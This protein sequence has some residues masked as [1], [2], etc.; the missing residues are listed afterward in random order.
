LLLEGD[1]ELLAGDQLLRDQHVPQTYSRRGGGRLH[2]GLYL[3]VVIWDDVAS[4]LT[5]SSP[6]LPHGQGLRLRS[7][8]RC[9]TNHVSA[10]FTELLGIHRRRRSEQ[11]R[12]RRRRRGDGD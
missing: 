4:I 5:R 9:Q 8:R 12:D 2:G 3:C 1:G 6:R 7:R 11:R 10:A